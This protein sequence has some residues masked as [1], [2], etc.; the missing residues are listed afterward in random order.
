MPKLTTVRRALLAAVKPAVDGVLAVA[1]VVTGPSK[2]DPRDRQRLG[3]VSMVIRA[4]VGQ[5]SQTSE[6]ALDLLL[7][8]EGG[9]GSLIGALLADEDLGDV[10]ASLRIVGSAG[11]RTWK[12]DS[13]PVLGTELTVEVQPK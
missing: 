2:A 8:P 10:V 5:P 3:A 4:Y 11:A 9:E 7:D 12:T 13:G 1:E 6:E